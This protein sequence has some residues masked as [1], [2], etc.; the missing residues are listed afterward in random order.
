MDYLVALVAAWLICAGL[1]SYVAVQKGRGGFEG[2]FFGLLL[3]PLGVLIAALMP[4]SPV[5]PASASVIPPHERKSYQKAA[6]KSPP[7]GTFG[8][9]LL[10][11]VAMAALLFLGWFH[12]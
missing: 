5:R 4:A 8:V 11:V 1:G 10:I 3:G 7:L 6:D 12:P 2:F 9:S